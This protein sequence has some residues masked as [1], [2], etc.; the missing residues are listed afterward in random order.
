MPNWVITEIECDS[1][2]TLWELRDFNHIIPQPVILDKTISGSASSHFD[3]LFKK[4][5]NLLSTLDDIHHAPISSD[6]LKEFAVWQ[7]ETKRYYLCKKLYGFSNWYDWRIENWGCKWN[8]LDFE[9]DGMCRFQ[10][11]WAHPFP[12]IEA[13]SRKYPELV[14]NV[15]FADECIGS[16]AGKYVIQNGYYLVPD[17]VVEYSREAYEIAFEIW[18]CGNDYRWDEEEH[19]YIYIDQAD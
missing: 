1:L 5:S 14:L 11:P 19:D 9:L 4:N 7:K 18:G 8:A 16:N 6:I 10:T 17:V 3:E 2:E 15:Q 13:F 12:I